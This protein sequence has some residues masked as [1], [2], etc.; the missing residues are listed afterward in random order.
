MKIIYLAVICFLTVSAATADVSRPFVLWTQGD[1]DAM[2]N[3]IKN[4]P[5]YAQQVKDLEQNTPSLERDFFDLWRIAI[6][7][8]TAA[9]D[10]QKSRL[11]QVTRSAAPR[12]GAQWLTVLRYDLLYDQLNAAERD[13]V[14]AFFRSYIQHAVFEN[15]LFDPEVFNDERNYSRYHAHYH[16]INNWLPN[17]TFPRILSANLMAAALQDEDLIRRTWAH[18]GSFKWYLDDYLTDGGFYGEEIGKMHATPGEMLVY[19]IALQNLG[20]N[21][22]GFG[23]RGRHGATIRGH[24]ESVLKLGFPVVE[25]HS[26]SPH[27][28]RMTAGD[29]RGPER[30]KQG[31]RAF[32]SS[33]IKGWLPD[34]SG[35]S[36]RWTAH[37][38]WGGEIRGNHP[39]WDG[40]TGFTPKM[41]IPFWFEIAHKQWPEAGFDYFLA[42]MRKPGA[43]SFLP[44]IYVNLPAIDPGKTQAPSAPSWVAEK[45][46]FIML[47]AEEA[48]AYWESAAPAVG[49][50]LAT[51]YAHDVFDNFALTGFYA[52]NRPLFI[53]R[54]IGG[55]AANWTRSVLS[56]A[57]V[58]VDGTEPAFTELS[59]VRY[60]FQDRIKFAA[61][62]SPALYPDINASRALFL[63]KEYLLDIFALSDRNDKER[64][65]RWALHPLGVAELDERWSAPQRLTGQLGASERDIG[66]AT[67]HRLLTGPQ[68]V[69]DTFGDMRIQTTADDWRLRIVQ[70]PV[71]PEDQ[72]LL[73]QEWYARAVGMNLRMLAAPGTV[74][75]AGTTPL[76]FTPEDTP[77][78]EDEPAMHEVTGTSILV[79]RDH[80]ATVFAAMYEPFEGG[81]GKINTFRRIAEEPD[82]IA[83]AVGSETETVHDFAM[84]QYRDTG[85]I[86]KAEDSSNGAVFEF[87][88]H[89]FIRISP[90][91]IEV[92]GDL[93][94]LQIPVAAE[95]VRYYHNGR[96]S[97]AEIENGILKY[98][99][100]GG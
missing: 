76:T 91:T 55:Y 72:R 61:A 18:Y 11:L 53:N 64:T 98:A 46:G 12:G 80:P 4:D 16:R 38:A 67:R 59:E 33:I 14:E 89:A 20:L 90:D 25:L 2:R 66:T 63:T 75:A 30:D 32:Q 19:C 96:L 13:E 47:R 78:P 8:D 26:G 99:A 21:E 70:Q 49:M 83:V 73:P 97:P 86:S 51:P 82:F 93:R 74:L 69:L 24:I 35:D 84:V 44:S 17:I 10:R 58:K 68:N 71:I 45:R 22:L 36:G 3:R 48:P 34:G 7:E 40:Y 37:G 79:R 92:F 41:Q 94:F 77:S 27:L 88:D 100:P 31:L 23:Y 9:R 65:Y 52:Y 42:L 60:N 81:S 62:F 1:I 87:R 54:Q 39:Q 43:E 28:P 85:R 29:L 50:R 6:L 57:G 95:N 5:A 56:H 15:A